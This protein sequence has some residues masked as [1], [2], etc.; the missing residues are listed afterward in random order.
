MEQVMNVM[1]RYPQLNVTFAHFLFLSEQPELLEELF[2]KYPNMAIDVTPGTEMYGVFTE[3]RDYYR[4]FF[5]KYADRIIFGSDAGIPKYDSNV[6]LVEAVY[7]VMTEDTEVEIWK[8]PARGLQLS[9]DACRLILCE[10]FLRRS[11]SQPKPVDREA[12]KRYVQKYLPLIRNQQT[13]EQI[14]RRF[15]E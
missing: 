5:E 13:K 12:L 2:A 1:Q 3:R 6:E 14:M 9:D 11:G 15:Y 10:N 4:T 7:R 8:L